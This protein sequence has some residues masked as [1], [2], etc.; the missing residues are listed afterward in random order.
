MKNPMSIYALSLILAAPPLLLWAL[1]V[2]L[3]L[4][5]L[6]LLKDLQLF[7]LLILVPIILFTSAAVFI[8]GSW[9]WIRVLQHTGI[10]DLEDY[11]E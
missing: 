4:Y 6:T 11:E 8:L 1:T 2:A 9:M 3:G 5:S 10:I 7:S